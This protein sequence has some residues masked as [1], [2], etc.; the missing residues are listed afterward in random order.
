MY[1]LQSPALDPAQALPGSIDA[2]AAEYA[3]RVVVLQP[4]GPVHLLGWS[5]GGILAQA[6]ATRLRSLGREVGVLALLDA[7]PLASYS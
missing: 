6:M 4:D 5:V 3:D 1:G 7:Y 2:L